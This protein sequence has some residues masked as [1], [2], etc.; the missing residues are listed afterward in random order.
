MVVPV[1]RR[2]Y[3]SDLAFL[4][5]SL[6]GRFTKSST[7]HESNVSGP[8]KTLQQWIFDFVDRVSFM[9]M[10]RLLTHCYMVQAGRSIH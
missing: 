7:K 4:F 8:A 5:G 9:K 1:L 6:Y 2:F 3:W 10:N